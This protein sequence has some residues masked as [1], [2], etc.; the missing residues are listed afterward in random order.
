MYNQERR[1]MIQTNKELTGTSIKKP[2]ETYSIGILAGTNPF[3]LS[4]NKKFNNPIISRSSFASENINFVA[5]PFA[6][7]EAGMWYL[8]F[9]SM[10]A[11]S[12]RGKLCVT[13]SHDL[14]KWSNPQVIIEEDFHLSYPQVFKWNDEFYMLPE[15][16]EANE[17]RLYVA[18]RFPY[19]WKFKKS[20][21][22][23]SCV[24]STL[25][26]DNELFWLFICDS[27][28]DHNSLRLFF[29]NDLEGEWTEHPQSPVLENN[30]EDSRPAGKLF[31]YADKLYRVA[32]NCA[33][34]YGHS[35]NVFEVLKIN[36]TEYKEVKLETNPLL[37]GRGDSWC[38]VSMHHIDLH[39]LSVNEWIAFV[40]GRKN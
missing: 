26:F 30:S 17:L 21:L 7:Y 25:Y 9:E 37:N 38:S 13:T 11:N 3:S 12:R 5:D 24:D 4:E 40:D 32:Q 16:Y 15:S 10:A 18:E 28:H 23:I 14:L 22:P 39:K 29:S 2:E 36:P 31:Q 20:V 35:V 8:F 6:L 1:G 34:F 33:P 19:E 27:P